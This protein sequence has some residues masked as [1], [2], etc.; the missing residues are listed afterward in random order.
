MGGDSELKRQTAKTLKWNAIDRVSSQVLYAL[1]G[2]VLANILSK[3]DFGLVG[4]LLVFQAFGI[5]FVDSG[6]GSALLQKKQPTQ[7]DYSTVFWFNL[8]VSL[9][10]YAILWL[11]APLIADIFQG[12][13][14]LIPM[15]RV[16]FLT[17][18]LNGTALV[19][20]TRLMKEMNVKMVAMANVIGLTLSGGIG[21]WL[22]LSGA[23]AWALVWQ[24]VTLSA[25]K[26]GWLWITGGWRPRRVFS[27]ES[28]KSIWRVGLSV[29]SSS[30]LNT[31]FLYIYSFVIGA[32]YNLTALGVYTQA[33]KWSKMGSASIS[34]VLTATFVPLLSRVQDDRES[35]NRYV[36]RINR[37]SAFI[38]FPVMLGGA[39]VGTPLFHTLFGTKWDA[40]VPLFQILMARGALIVLISVYNNY[41]LALGY[42][43]KIFT[44]ELVKDGMIA[45]AVLATVWH[46][47]VEALVWGQLT[48]SAATWA[49]VLAIVCHSTGYSASKMGGDLLPFLIAGGVCAGGAWAVSLLG[50]P[51]VVTL[52]VG[53]IAGAGIYVGIAAAF[54]LPELQEAA[55]YLRVRIGKKGITT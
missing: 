53:V 23:G 36:K 40:A 54:R 28:M 38:I 14:R 2:I 30:A 1:T 3:E 5:L 32:F 16:M 4:A 35:F 34:Q 10:V 7:R 26:S 22:A 27:I 43:R 39:A 29:F 13:Q 46:G 50:L 21:I 31:F 25:V 55:D 41:L 48:A 49:I 17:F 45:L 6:F 19:Q 51:S 20:T 42:A 33:D 47:T 12:D 24:S 18:V 44:V 9:L 11:G 52:I 8:G 37:F 15:S